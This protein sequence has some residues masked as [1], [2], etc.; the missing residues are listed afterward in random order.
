MV[1]MF[2]IK[3]G[4]EAQLP[5]DLVLA[6]QFH[7]TNRSVSEISEL[8]HIWCCALVKAVGMSR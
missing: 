1:F 4:F 6:V 8:F 5:N 2:Q 3:E 7:W